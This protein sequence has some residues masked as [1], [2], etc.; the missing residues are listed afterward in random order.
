MAGVLDGIRVIDL[1]W[2]MAG[3]MATM[4]LAD[5]GAQVTRIEPPDGDPFAE[6]SGQR[7]WLRGKRRAVL[8]LRDPADA[9]SL[10]ALVGAADV[11]VESFGPGTARRLGV[12]YEQ[13]RGLNPR[14]VHCSLTGYGETGPDA[15]RPA[16]D[17]LVAARTG[18]LREHRGVVGGT[19]SLISGGEGML[20]GI[21]P[22][23]QDCW[24]GPARKG[25]LFSGVPWPS[26]ATA[27]NATLV[28]NAALRARETTGRGQHV[29][30]SLL[31]G[32]LTNTIG[33]W[34]RIERHDAPFLQSWVIDP[35]APKGFWRAADGRWTHH[36]VPLPGFILGTAE[37]HKVRDGSGSGGGGDE[38]GDGTS[39]Y[40]VTAPREAALRVGVDPEEMLVLHHYDQEFAEAVGLLTAEEWTRTA[41]EV[42]V[43]VQT[44]RSPEEALLDPAFLADGCV[45]ELADPELGPV[46]QVGSVLR[47]S[48]CPAGPPAPRAAPGRHT[49][50][51]K[52]E[53][54][55]LGAPTAVELPDANRDLAA[56]LAGIRVLDLGL[57]VAGPFGT[58][59]LADLGAEVIKVNTARDGYWFASHLAMCCNRGKRS[60]ALD[61]KDP[62]GRRVLERLVGTADVV[63]HN[64][65]HEAAVRLGADYES[66]R[67]IKPD[68][69]YCHTRG[70]EHGAR[71][72][73]PGNDQTGAALTGVSWLD[74]AADNGGRP[75]WSAC[76]AGDT[77]NG[78]LSAIGIV[79]ALYHRDRTGEGQFVDT[80]IVYAHLLNAS[81][82]WVAPDGSVSGDRPRPDSMGYGWSA[83]YG[84]YRGREG[85]LCLAALT[86]E[87]W[88]AL[89]LALN[90]PGLAEDRRFATAAARR[91]HDT[92]LRSALEPAFGAHTAE[93]SF[94]VL[95]AVGVPCEVVA[96]DFPRRLH[97]DQELHDKGWVTTYQHRNVGRM[98][99]FGLMFDLADTPG[100]IAGP[101]PLVGEHT[102]GILA[103]L[104]CPDEEIADLIA[105]RIAFDEATAP[106]P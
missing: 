26:V 85:W 74:G 19:L 60:I 4:L 67:R 47:H 7:V 69:V 98:D 43:P 80:S 52:A 63:Q 57:A 90:V 106:R 68:L 9:E 6:L 34:Q 92:E 28:I 56:P 59:L 83:L 76:A 64:M 15:D 66:L 1:S 48:A 49:A 86:E 99:V 17:A 40:E 14:L 27:Y 24:V 94:A 84:L 73:L 3:P 103:E 31:Q 10:R 88:R 29:H 105:R 55:R 23:T 39:G 51:V 89:C 100:R 72:S 32:V 102:R 45:V 5:H 30:T 62:A 44:V 53:A 22:P 8:D 12:S 20:P 46:R 36:W 38:N 87:H 101:P 82:A 25:P 16:Y 13:L 70:F 18:Q 42:G 61:L 2:G 93:K 58:Q 65:R 79:Q 37:R 78:F 91:S 96:N 35:R 41:A 104:G 77:G 54:A 21:E 97:D 33:S 11:L 95:D 71:D 50:E 75:L 81:M